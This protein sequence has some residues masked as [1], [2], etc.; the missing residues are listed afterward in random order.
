MRDIKLMNEVLSNKIAA[1]EIIERPLSVVKELVENAIDAN[2]TEIIIN[3]LDSGIRNIEVLDNGEGMNK[4]NILMCV[5]RHATSKLYDEKELFKIGTLG[6]RGEALA[7]MGVVSQMTIT[8]SNDGISGHQL[9]YRSEEDYE[10]KEV[11]FNKGTKVEVSNLFYNTPVRYKHLS[12][13]FYELAIIVNYISKLALTKPNISFILTNDEKQ[14]IHTPGNGDMGSIFTSIYSLNIAKSMTNFRGET[15][16]F[17]VDIYYASPEYTKSRK[18]Y[19]TI[20]LNGRII[21]NYDIE[22]AIV[23]SYKNF[24]HINQYPIVVINIEADYHLI[25]VNIHPTKQQ[26][27]ISMIKEL[28]Q[29]IINGIKS[30][31][32]KLLYVPQVNITPNIEQDF[33]FKDSSDITIDY[34]IS[35]VEKTREQ[36]DIKLEK[37]N[38]TNGIKWQLPHFEY[39]GTLHAT[40]LLFENNEGLH[41]VDQHAAQERINYEKIFEKFNKKEFSMQQILVPVI[42]EVSMEEFSQIK[43]KL[44][45]LKDLGIII[46]EFGI[47]TFKV[48]EIDNFYMKARS[49]ETDINNMFKLILKDTKLDFANIYEDAAIMM[50]CKSSIKANQYINRLEVDSLMKQLNECT[51]PFTCP[52][53]RPVI[54]N[55]T[56][57][58]I[59]KLFKRV[60]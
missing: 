31:L 23:N 9:K 26:V 45:L 47:N 10:L 5:K 16:N 32:D 36:I 28:E 25:D 19:M 49:L 7:S 57:R 12:N 15:E 42:I 46:E 8:S 39:V 21:K 6:F 56:T 35:K 38:D 2:S 34:D 40:Y 29:L 24:L 53:G 27:K 20:S 51:S 1:G 22:N 54:V 41:L 48:V 37:T 59:E 4:D 44:D 43:D 55:V 60:V 18:T 14:L 52:H 13:P 33:L 3:L 58:E 17:N 50:A 11:G 30:G